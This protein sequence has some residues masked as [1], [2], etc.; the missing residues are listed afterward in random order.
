MAIVTGQAIV[1]ADVLAVITKE[2][3]IPVTVASDADIKGHI[4]CAIIDIEGDTAYIAFYVPHD[5]SSITEAV[6]ARISNASAT[7][8][9]NYY[10]DYGAVGEASTTNSESL[11]D[12]DTAET[13]TLIYEQ[14]I[15]GI[16]S[17]LAAGD[18]VGIAVAG[19]ATNEPDVS[20]LGV[21][22]KYS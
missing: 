20:I 10:S 22:F 14:D 15:S 16:L 8:R 13:D 4:P 9:L 2:F 17:S 11:L 1:A 12:Q 19:D 18:Y 3:F 7:H 6:V 21:R 5:F